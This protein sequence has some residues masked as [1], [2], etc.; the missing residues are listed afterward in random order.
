MKATL[1]NVA[2][3]G[4]SKKMKATFQNVARGK[5]ENENVAT[6]QNFK[7]ESEATLGKVAFKKKSRRR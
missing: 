2:S 7:T 1:A 6:D 5:I 3:G 4:V